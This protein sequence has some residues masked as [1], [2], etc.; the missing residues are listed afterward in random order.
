MSDW[1]WTDDFL[2][3]SRAHQSGKRLLVWPLL[4]FIAAVSIQKHLTEESNI[5]CLALLCVLTAGHLYTNV[6][7]I[8][9]WLQSGL[10]S[11]LSW[12]LLN[13]EIF[14]CWTWTWILVTNEPNRICGSLIS[15]FTVSNALKI[16]FKRH[17]I[18]SSFVSHLE[19][20]LLLLSGED[21]ILST[22]WEVR[23]QTCFSWTA[24]QLWSKGI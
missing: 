9:I 10:E 14:H 7:L 24:T 5:L 15:L 13:C 17:F 2:K 16:H 11:A 20:I 1:W 19:W 4:S 6:W 18:W 23:K 21:L 12:R 22:L 8:V 3:D